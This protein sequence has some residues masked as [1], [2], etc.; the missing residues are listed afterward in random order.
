MT[1]SQP[2]VIIIGGGNVGYYLARHL[3]ERDYEV[4]LIEKNPKRAEWIEHHL[5]SL[6]IMVG[7]GDELSFVR[8]TGIDRANVVIASTADDE[9]NLVACQ[10]AKFAF[11]VPRTIARV[12]NP[13]NT[14]IMPLLG[15]D[16]GVSSTELLMGLIE[17]ELG[18]TEVIKAISI[19]A[20]GVSIIDVAIPENSEYVGSQVDSLR[21]PE[22]FHLVS[23]VRDGNVQ[24]PIP[25]Y[26]L[27]GGDELIVHSERL[28]PEA[29][30]RAILGPPVQS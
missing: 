11:N 5:G 26:I 17:A 22:G 3:L 1:P 13:V 23:I 29:L 14:R 4:T 7:D 2:Y 25:T 6:N 9:D 24:F 18:H 16:V 30:R 8:T 12:N 20:S 21:L 10:I 28:D 15:V 19:K 27:H